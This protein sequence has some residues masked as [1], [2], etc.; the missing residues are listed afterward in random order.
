MVGD[1]SE[2]PAVEGE[3]VEREGGWRSGCGG[4]HCE[5][6]DDLGR[7]LGA[8]CSVQ[9]RFVWNVGKARGVS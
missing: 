6:V 5:L 1:E 3:D 2:A 9:L 8:G 4:G 7:V